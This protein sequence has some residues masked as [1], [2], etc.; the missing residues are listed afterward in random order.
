M[1]ASIARRARWFGGYLIVSLASAT[2]VSTPLAAPSASS[3]EQ[4][5]SAYRAGVTAAEAGRWAEA[6]ARFREAIALRPSPK[7]VFSLAQAEEH[8]GE[9]ASAQ[10]S[11]E[12]AR[13]SA[14]A[15][16]END[17][18]SASEQAEAALEPRIPHLHVVTTGV[19]DATA[20][21]DGQ[22]V[23]T[24]LVVAADP[25]SH[26][27]VVQA[28]GRQPYTATISLRE[29]QQLEV[30]VSLLPLAP[31]GAGTPPPPPPVART[32]RTQSPLATAGLVAA[33]VGVVGVAIG[34][35]FGIEARARNDQSYSGG[36]QGNACPANAAAVR[37][38]ALSWAHASTAA[39]IAGGA[40]VASGVVV[41]LVVPPRVTTEGGA[42]EGSVALVPN[43]TGLALRATW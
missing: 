22:R 10:A 34:A 13:T 26:A 40:L 43:G 7:A 30:V 42:A 8:L 5:K 39:F 11:Y 33:G 24:S 38:S 12:E 41:W 29:R 21:L 2:T 14:R 20:T 36:C 3:E 23:A 27:L 6:R 19:L 31:L 28:T 25:G 16:G 4:R 37:E 35:A 1:S 17:V 9:V 15:A 32:V 18:V